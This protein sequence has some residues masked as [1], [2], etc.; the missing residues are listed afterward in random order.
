MA[1]ANNK[2]DKTHDRLTK[3]VNRLKTDLNNEGNMDADLSTPGV[4][5]TGQ[6]TTVDTCV[7]QSITP[8]VGQVQ[9]SHR[10]NFPENEE[11][12]KEI[13]N[14][15]ARITKSIKKNTNPN[16]LSINKNLQTPVGN[17]KEPISKKQKSTF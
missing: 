7:L 4:P 9:S 14:C 16:P 15:M 17:L 10:S 11:S 5:N 3:E 1:Q 12:H 13:K 2:P 8:Q 6:T